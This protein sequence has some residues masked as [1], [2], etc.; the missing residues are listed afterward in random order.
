MFFFGF[1]A[2]LTTSWRYFEPTGPWGTPPGL[3]F[4]RFGFDFGGFWAPC[5]LRFG[6]R[7]VAI[8]EHFGTRAVPG[9]A[10]GVT[11]SVKN[12]ELNLH[13]LQQEI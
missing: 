8:L 7:V 10:G 1:L 4:G 13:S 5:W 3:D 11:R 2:V 9:W 6:C 12:F